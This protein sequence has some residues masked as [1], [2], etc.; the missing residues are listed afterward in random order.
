MGHT[1]RPSPMIV[2]TC[3]RQPAPR[4]V[5]QGG[6]TLIEL[7]F[8]VVLL[9]ILIALAAPSL[10]DIVR[11]QR[12]K[13]A[14]FDVYASLVFARSEAIKRNANINIIPTGADWAGGWQVQVQTGG[15]VLKTQNVLNG[16]KIMGST[17]GAEV[18][19]GTITYQRD[20]RLTATPPMI[21]VQSSESTSITARCV[22]LDVSGRPNVKVDTDKDPSNAC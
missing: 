17:G 7:M 13:T 22:R 16:L 2:S 10:R 21:V 4:P 11:D 18:N 8:S 20:G 19:V 5:A 12:V 14:T 6:F 15:T 1:M 9:V 3:S